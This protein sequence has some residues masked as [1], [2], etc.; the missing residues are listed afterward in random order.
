MLP[1]PHWRFHSSNPTRALTEQESTNMEIQDENTR[2]GRCSEKA[3]RDR[4]ANALSE[5]VT[6]L[7]FQC[8][9]V[10]LAVEVH[11]T[12]GLPSVSKHE[13]LP[14]AVQWHAMVIWTPDLGLAR[15]HS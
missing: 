5:A 12:G 4:D 6:P 11:T 2:P 3:T 13:S 8:L 7:I 9:G 15:C 14:E 1:L 10:Q